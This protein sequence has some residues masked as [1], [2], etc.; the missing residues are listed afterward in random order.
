MDQIE[1]FEQWWN[2]QCRKGDPR[3]RLHLTEDAFI[4][5]YRL[6]VDERVE[7]A[8]I[9]NSLYDACCTALRFLE[10][11]AL[12]RNGPL[13]EVETLRRAIGVAQGHTIPVVPKS[14][15][16]VVELLEANRNAHPGEGWSECI[17]YAQRIIREQSQ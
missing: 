6:T 11:N 13:Q 10:P 16:H 2:E 7:D 14:A 17:T 9:I 8:K 5:G 15:E 4:A 12:A 3:K 1:A